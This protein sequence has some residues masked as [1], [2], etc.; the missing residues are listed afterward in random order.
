MEMTAPASSLNAGMTPY[1]AEIRILTSLRYLAAAWVVFFHWS[2]YFPDTALPGNPLIRSGFL[3]VDFFFIL[4]GFVLSHVYIK[5]T[6]EGRLD[7]WNFI[8]RRFARI[9][10]M[11]FLT[12]GA[13]IVFGVVA[14]RLALTFAGPWSPDEFLA[15]AS[16]EAPRELFGNLL[17]IHA[18]GAGD[19]LH[20]NA[21]SW[22]I[23]AE[24]FAYLLFPIL[25]VMVFARRLRAGT[26]LGLI[27]I[28]IIIFGTVVEAAARRSVF[29]MSWNI[30]VLRI[31]PD[32]IYGIALYRFGQIFSLGRKAAAVT[33][34]AS[35]MAIVLG[36][37][38]AIP[39]QLMVLNFGLFI[40]SGADLER[41]GGAGLFRNG[42]FVLLGEISYSL[43]MVHFPFGIVVFG[44]IIQPG[45]SATA[46][47]G[48]ALIA[49]MIAAATGLSY[50]TYRFVEVPTRDLINRG[51]ARIIR[52]A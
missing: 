42:F 39:L 43:Y 29:E 52:R 32:F 20:F 33:L 4:S 28:G 17:L 31:A 21:P 37:Y 9:Y 5:R 35:F 49:V 22:S 36:A 38:A 7:Y 30:G 47:G 46:M 24:W 25:A 6:V 14:H 27:A 45:Q 40:F 13:M 44:L 1:P 3:G 10:P 12:L 8:S 50:L 15:L 48:I 16:G 26:M 11:H 23:S 34:T 2:S 41:C 19:G 18:W 51:S